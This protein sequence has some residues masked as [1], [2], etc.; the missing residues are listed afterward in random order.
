MTGAPAGARRGRD[1]ARLHR[2]ISPAACGRR[3]RFDEC[4]E[5]EEAR[6]SQSIAPYGIG[7]GATGSAGVGCSQVDADASGVGGEES[8]QYRSALQ[9]WR[10]GEAQQGGGGGGNVGTTHNSVC[11]GET[12]RPYRGVC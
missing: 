10:S 7:N 4:G 9:Q 1:S 6:G 12:G 11:H 5:M 3:T 8:V 2:Y